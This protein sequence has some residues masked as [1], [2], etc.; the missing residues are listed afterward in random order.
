MALIECVP[1][2]SEGRRSEVVDEIVEA[3]R[4]VPT[5]RV[6]DVSSDPSHNRSVITMI[7]DATG[8]KS[9]V[10]SLFERAI[11]SID[12]RNHAGE[13]PRLGAVDVVPFVPVADVSMETCVALARDTAADVASRFDLPVFL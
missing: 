11:R 5:V 1:N 2:I 9:A 8:T 4:L 3:I 7:G 13:H 12:L 10:L 6:L